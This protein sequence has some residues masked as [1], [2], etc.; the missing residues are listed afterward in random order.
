MERETLTLNVT[1][2]MD[3][4]CITVDIL[5]P[6]SGDSSR[7]VTSYSPDEHPEFNER[8]GDELYCWILE[9]MDQTR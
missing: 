1:L 7:V 3:G 8:V 4:E 6:E 9:H 2:R 5:E